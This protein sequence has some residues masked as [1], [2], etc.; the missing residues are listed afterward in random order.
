MSVQVIF[1][2]KFVSRTE[3]TQHLILDTILHIYN[4]ENSLELTNWLFNK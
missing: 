2:R 1:G 3:M 4:V